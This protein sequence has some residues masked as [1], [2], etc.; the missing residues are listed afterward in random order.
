VFPKIIMSGILT[1]ID[2]LSLGNVSCIGHVWGM[3]NG[4]K[5]VGG[6]FSDF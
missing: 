5:A 1:A 3:S 4:R 2:M 6:T